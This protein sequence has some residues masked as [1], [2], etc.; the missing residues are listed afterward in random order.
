VRIDYFGER[1][2]RNSVSRVQKGRTPCLRTACQQGIGEG[3]VTREAD[4]R[5][6]PVWGKRANARNFQASSVTAPIT[7]PVGVLANTT[8]SHSS[9]LSAAENVVIESGDMC[10][11]SVGCG[12]EACTHTLSARGGEKG[13]QRAIAAPF[14]MT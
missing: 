3:V 11:I 2:G 14:T 7:A 10:R 1:E 9:G 12:G 5:A 6:K 8:T 13:E 4:G